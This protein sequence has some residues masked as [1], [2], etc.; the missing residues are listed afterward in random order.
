MTK[1]TRLLILLF[2]V[3]C[4]LAIAP[5]L[6]AYSMGYRFDFE[7]REVVETGGIYVRTF[8]TAEQ[9]IINSKIIAKPGIFSNAIFV[10]S[11]L[12]KNHTVFV[13]KDGYYDYFKTLLV[14]EKTVTKLENVTLFKKSLA[15]NLISDGID[16]FSIAPNNQNIITASFTAKAVTLN[17]F[18]LN[19]TD[20][21]QKISIGTIGK[22]SEIKWSEDSSTALIKIQNSGDIFY[23]FFDLAKQKPT[24]TRL[25]YLD[26]NSQQINFNPRDAHEILYEE[27]GT[28]YSLKN[29]IPKAVIKNLIAYTISGNKIL[30]LSVSGTLFES[31][32]A[33][34]LILTLTD[35][36]L[37]ISKNIDYEITVVSEK[38]FL[39]GN[40]SVLLFNPAIKMFESLGTPAGDYKILN[41]PDSKNLILWNGDEVYVYSY[42]DKSYGKLYSGF[43]IINFQWL[44]N[45]YIVF[46][47]GDKIIISEIDYRGNINAVI[48]PEA[49]IID[50]VKN[51]NTINPQTF[52]IQHSGKLY[53]L[54]DGFLSVSEKITP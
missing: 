37:A 15:F 43:E 45:D 29:N 42:L 30:W 16:Y 14:Q 9:V 27:N 46:T 31:D 12:P 39:L 34:R 22:I 50:D 6:V 21:L 32:P 17:Y 36:D 23:Y 26:K 53:I 7:K 24:V 13:K 8:P 33:G 3:I 44:N 11:L 40:S 41:S 47:S 49:L 18:N 4:F 28:L 38:I 10:Q 25:P 52:Y 48:L 20:E 35:K 54:S 2:C 19:K 1:K 51:I 5:V